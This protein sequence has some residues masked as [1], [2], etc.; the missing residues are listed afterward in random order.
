MRRNKTIRI[1]NAWMLLMVFMSVLVVKDTCLHRV[2]NEADRHVSGHA[3][4]Q[5]FCS[6]CDFVLQ[7]AD[8]VEDFT[9]IPQITTSVITRYLITEL[10]VYRPITSVNAHSPPVQA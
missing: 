3:K 8:V 1:I 9:F 5:S 2:D 7:K 6:I 10:T 4:L